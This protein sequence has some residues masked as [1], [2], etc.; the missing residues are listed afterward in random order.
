MMSQ[1]RNQPTYRYPSLAHKN[2][3]RQYQQKCHL[4]H[5]CYQYHKSTSC[6]FCTACTRQVV[7]AYKGQYTLYLI[8]FTYQLSFLS[9]TALP[10]TCIFHYVCRYNLWLYC[11]YNWCHY[12]VLQV[13][14]VSLLCTICTICDPILYC[15]YKCFLTQK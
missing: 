4:P 9:V 15:M 10:Q 2:T 7:V 8:V 3:H 5:D 13:K 14:V 11:R 6:L 1:D 12:Y